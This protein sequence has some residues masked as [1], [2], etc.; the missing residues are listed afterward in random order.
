MTLTKGDREAL[1]RSHQSVST[2]LVEQYLAWL[3]EA[4][5]LSRDQILAEL[6]SLFTFIRNECAAF[7]RT[8]KGNLKDRVLLIT[9]ALDETI[10][11][12]R[13]ERLLA[14]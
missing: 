12:R 9:K 4:G 5:V 3:G 8:K 14:Q 10:E 7:G 11:S 13:A 6:C 1:Q 2:R